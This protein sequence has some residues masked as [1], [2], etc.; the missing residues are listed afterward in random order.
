MNQGLTIA[1]VRTESDLEAVRALCLDFLQW[2]RARYSHLEW[3]IERYYDPPNWAA[4]L[5]RLTRLYA[6]PLGDILL[7]RLGA[8]AVGCV[9]MQP[10]DPRTCEMKHLFV[11]GIARGRNVGFRLCES[12]MTLAAQRGFQRMHLET[13]IENKEAIA[14]YTRLGFRPREPSSDYPAT[15]RDLLRFMSADLAGWTPVS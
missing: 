13:G 1:V 2:N 4:Y 11:S 15:V 6:P 8:V 7:A 10:V 9:M 3:L 12:L 14:L 5:S